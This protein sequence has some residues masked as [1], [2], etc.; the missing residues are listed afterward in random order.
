MSERKTPAEF[1]KEI[2]DFAEIE[3][4]EQKN[5]VREELE[6]SLDERLTRGRC[7]TDLRYFG[8]TA[9]GACRF[10][11][12]D[13]L[14]DLREGD[15]VIIHPGN[16]FEFTSLM[17]WAGDGFLPDGKEYVDLRFSNKNEV[18][19]DASLPYT[20]DAYYLDMSDVIL[21]AIHELGSTERGRE[22]ILPLFMGELDDSVSLDE[23]DAAQDVAQLDGFND[24]QQEAIASAVASEWCSLI[25]GPPGTGK[26]RV[27]A[28]IVKQRVERGERIL[29][30]ACTHRAIHEALHAVHQAMPGF[31][32]IAKISQPVSDS[33]LCVP[34][35]ENFSQSPLVGISGAYVVGATAYAAR[36]NRLAG[37]EFDCVI[38]DEASQMTLPLAI[39]AM[40]SADT[41][42]L[43]GDP[44]QLP[45][46]VASCSAFDAACYSLFS[47]ISLPHD[48]VRLN[49]TYRMNAEISNWVAESFY[50]GDLVPAE[51]CKNRM[52]KVPGSGSTKWLEEVLSEKNSLVWI[53]T[54]TNNTRQYSMEEAALIHEIICELFRRGFDLSDVAVIT[55]FRRQARIIR[56]RLMQSGYLVPDMLSS[57]V[58]DTVDRMQ[59]QERPL[60]IVST[61]ASDPGFLAAIQ[62][63]VY[64]PQRLNVA[65]SRAR[66][67]C[68]VLG[69]DSFVRPAYINEEIV[70]AVGYWSSLRSSSVVVD[71]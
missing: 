50:S 42:V 43:I 6:R 7:V 35:H 34:V 18:S 59:G 46:V 4:R 9:N 33:R 48:L 39:M 22:R 57:V 8:R 38:V 16:P 36:N 37:V 23:Y 20:V 11:C 55:P 19:F 5:S 70:E 1:Y 60:I 41:Y 54:S 44:K 58:I 10:V 21:R 56:R 66:S 2:L 27:L 3:L 13:N 65:V 25:Q 52:L 69:S 28:N 14:S 31:D 49:V 67:K 53:P 15:I 29:I 45:P 17:S 64:L 24:R 47:R 51:S 61:A 32:R 12:A 30:T 68:I 40:L 71:V 62:E 63:F 26:T